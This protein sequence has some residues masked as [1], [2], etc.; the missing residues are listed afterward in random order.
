MHRRA[1]LIFIRPV[2]EGVASE[3]CLVLSE[4]ISYKRLFLGGPH[5]WR[6]IAGVMWRY[7]CMDRLYQVVI[8]GNC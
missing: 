3:E 8:C 2:Y 5:L 6:L 7:K 1:D 4:L